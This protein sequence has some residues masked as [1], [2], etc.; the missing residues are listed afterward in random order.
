MYVFAIK[1]NYDFQNGFNL[2]LILIYLNQNYINHDYAVP[3]AKIL[4]PSLTYPLIFLGIF[5]P[6]LQ[7]GQFQL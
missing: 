1:R 7:L 2:L 4:P 3:P 6:P 5:S